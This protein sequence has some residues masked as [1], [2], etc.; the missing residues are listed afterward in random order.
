MATVQTLTRDAASFIDDA[1]RL[2]GKLRIGEA[3]EAAEQ[4]QALE[5]LQVLMADI[6]ADSST[7]H[8]RALV[9]VPLVAGQGMYEINTTYFVIDVHHVQ[10]VE[11]GGSNVDRPLT[12][13]SEGMYRQWPQKAQQGSVSQYWYD[14][15][16]VS[17]LYTQA[18]T[19]ATP[20]ATKLY[21]ISTP[22][23]QA[24][25]NGAQLNINASVRYAVPTLVT[26]A[27]DIPQ[28]WYRAFLY[29]FAVE[30][31]MNFGGGAPEMIYP[32][33]TELWETAMANARPD[34]VEFVYDLDTNLD[35]EHG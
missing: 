33:A 12:R 28:E 18:A 35:Y 14:R 20:D 29:R 9:Q 4:A 16:P 17:S 34:T 24:V 21:I 25:A 30:L 5:I 31:D 19:D 10:Y 2:I 22:T 15:S 32:M 1:F 11:T 8:K 6:Q 7:P 26:D 13:M 3:L 27:M 23:A